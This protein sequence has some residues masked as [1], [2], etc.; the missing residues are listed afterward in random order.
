MP[1]PSP[2]RRTP[3][4]LPGFR[5]GA[6]HAYA[7]TTCT[8]GR[9]PIL[10][11]VDGDGTLHPTPAGEIVRNVWDT[12]PD[13]F[14]ALRP[15][16]FVVMPDHVHGVVTIDPDAPTPVTL[17]MVVGALKSLSALRI[18]RLAGE[19]GRAVWQR[20]FHDRVIRDEDEFSQWC[21]YVEDNPRRWA[22]RSVWAP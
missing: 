21:W 19:P 22:A 17:T 15:R 13:R 1:D 5:Y 12:L 16:A 4:R 11:T 6:N 14:P 10:G 18:N 8:A 2:P 20:S 9:A 3:T 7:F